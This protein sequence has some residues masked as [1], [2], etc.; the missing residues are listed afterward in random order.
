[1]YQKA[2]P[3]PDR[4]RCPYVPGFIMQVMEHEPPPPFGP[5]GGPGG[6]PPSSRPVW[7]AEWLK[8][9][10]QTQQVL[11][12]PP[13]DTQW[14]SNTSPRTAVL[15]I[16][17]TIRTGQDRG[18]QLVVCQVLLRGQ[19]E[20]STVVAKI[21][22]SLYYSPYHPFSERLYDVVRAADM[23][24]SREAAAYRHLQATKT[25]QR[26]G[27]APEYYGSWTFKLALTRQGKEHKRSIR[28]VLIE[29][30]P[31]SPIGNLFTLKSFK[32][33]PDAFQY[34]ETYRLN[35]LAEIL[36]GTTKQ[37]HSGVSQEDRR[38]M[39]VMLVPSPQETIPPRSVPRVVLI[40][41]NRAVVHQHTKYG[42]FPSE[43]LNL[44]INPAE[45]FWSG[46]E[47]SSWCGWAPSQWYTHCQG[48]EHYQKWLLTKFGGDNMGRFEPI[49]KQLEFD[50]G[51][52]DTGNI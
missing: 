35:V 49:R 11:E 36:E 50:S 3:D 42:P 16:T 23:D 45:R 9:T 27:F 28:L 32:S 21:Y 6:Y 8:S 47:M 14:S 26:P 13:L 22:D 34:D 39:N 10:P 18:A 41:Y 43:S 4:P 37:L 46:E 31:G 7:S 51:P 17:K 1:M 44:P 24:Y 40:D 52:V 2:P 20:S 5:G 48:K 33:T 25:R 38:P 30:I 29:H 15:T 12:N 19:K